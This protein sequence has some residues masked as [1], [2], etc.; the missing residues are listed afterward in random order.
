MMARFPRTEAEGVQIPDGHRYLH[1]RGC[2]RAHP[3]AWERWR[4]ISRL[5]LHS[6][7]RSTLLHRCGADAGVR[8]PNTPEC[9]FFTP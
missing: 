3:L 7:A 5:Q 8:S 6:Q 2:V 1:G 9:C 4:F